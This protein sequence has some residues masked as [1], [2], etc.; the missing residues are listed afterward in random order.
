MRKVFLLTWELGVPLVLLMP[1]DFHIFWIQ[2]LIS[3][4]RYIFLIII[5]TLEGLKGDQFLP[6]LRFLVF[7]YMHSIKIV[8]EY[9]IKL[10]DVVAS[11]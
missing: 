4:V 5:Y 11:L 3:K 2:A 8:I 7:S 10:M 1:S 6:K 9:Q